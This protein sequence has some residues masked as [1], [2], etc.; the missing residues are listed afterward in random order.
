[1]NNS[2]R[3]RAFLAIPVIGPCGGTYADGYEEIQVGTAQ[4]IGIHDQEDEQALKEHLD[5]IEKMM[6]ERF[7]S[8][9]KSNKE[10]EQRINLG[11]IDSLL[12]QVSGMELSETNIREALGAICHHVKRLASPANE[13]ATMLKA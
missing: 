10:P 3:T 7:P 8:L 4:D 6:R 13:P 2:P 9:F 1:M 5:E 11:T 12:H